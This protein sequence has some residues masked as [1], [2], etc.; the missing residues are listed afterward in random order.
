MI[1]AAT[2]AWDQRLVSE[3]TSSRTID[4]PTL[5]IKTT[6]FGLKPPNPERL[7][8]S[9]LEH[10]RKFYARDEIREY[11]KQFGAPAPA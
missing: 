3:S 11:V 9:G 2:E 10:A 8:V 1:Q 4:I 6:D 5:E 7:Y